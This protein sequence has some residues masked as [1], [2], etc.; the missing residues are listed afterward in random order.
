MNHGDTRYDPDATGPVPSPAEMERLPF[1]L[2]V[3]AVLFNADRLVFAAQRADMLSDAWQMPQ[4][5]IDAG[6]DPEAAVFRELEEEIGTAKARI[7]A[8]TPDWLTYDLPPELVPKLWQGR[9]RGQ[10][11]KWYALE[12][13]GADSEIDIFKDPNPEFRAWKWARLSEVSERIVPFK[14]GMYERLRAEF[15]HLA[16]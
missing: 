7:L 16:R 12:F 15:G 14:R 3:G 5:G 10:K 6:E 4:G 8:E 9:Y 2:G 1:R 11:Q 13:L